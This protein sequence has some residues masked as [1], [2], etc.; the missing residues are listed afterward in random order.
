MLARAREETGLAIVTEV[1][2]CE[3]IDLVARHADVLQVGSRNMH[4]THLLRCAGR[5]AKPVLL[6]R[7]WC[8]SLQEFLLAAEYVMLEGNRNVILCE[9]GIRTFATRWRLP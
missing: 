5:Q 8:A 1:M 2:R 6:K 3:H 9:R 7:G 4:N